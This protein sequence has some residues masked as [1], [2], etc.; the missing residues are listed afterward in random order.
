MGELLK[1]KSSTPMYMHSLVT[2]SIC[3]RLDELGLMSEQPTGMVETKSLVS[4]T[5]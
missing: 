2:R 4:E 5:T 1:I 3:H